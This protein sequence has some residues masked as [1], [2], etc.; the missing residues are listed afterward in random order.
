V[1]NYRAPRTAFKPGHVPANKS[2]GMCRT[3]EYARWFSMK[4]RCYNP[5]DSNFARYGGRGITVCDRWRND[6]QA[7]F[8]D[9]GPPPTP[10]H[11]IERIDNDGPY[12]PENCRWATRTEQASNRHTNQ[13]ITFRGETLTV[14]EWARR[15]G[16]KA[17]ALYWRLHDGWDA[18]R[19][20]TTPTV[21]TY[22]AHGLTLTLAEW[23]KRLGV[24][25]GTL[26]YRINSGWPH[27]RVFSVSR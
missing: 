22:T 10:A 5:K 8:A 24:K 14:Q 12:S 17:P 25:K 27:E 13:T 18:E 3:P 15:T 11:Q 6:F 23:S 16:I 4:A 21:P 19:I 7:F 20:L 26:W 9:M 1:R 2:H